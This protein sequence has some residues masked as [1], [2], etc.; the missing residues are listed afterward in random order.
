MFKYARNTKEAKFNRSG[1]T[2]FIIGLLMTSFLL[3]LFCPAP[4]SAEATFDQ[5]AV[6]VEASLLNV[7]TGPSTSYEQIKQ[8]SSGQ[9][10]EVYSYDQDW[11]LVALEGGHSGWVDA[12]Y[13]SYN[14]ELKDKLPDLLEVEAEVEINLLNMRTG[15]G[16]DYDQIGTLPQKKEATV[17]EEKEG[18]LKV[19]AGEE[20]G[21]IS[22]QYIRVIKDKPQEKEKTEP[23]TYFQLAKVVPEILRVR[24]GPGLDRE[25]TEQAF[26]GNHLLILDREKGWHNVL[27]PGGAEGWVSSDYTE[28]KEILSFREDHQSSNPDKNRDLQG[29]TIVLDPGHGGRDGGATGINGLKEKEVCLS[30][31]LLLEEKLKEKGARVVLTRDRDKDLSMDQ[32]LEIESEAG[33]DILVSIHANAHP[34]HFVSGTETFYHPGDTNSEKSYELASSLQ[35]EL[36]RSFQLPCLGVK[37]AEFTILKESTTPSA[38]VELAFLSNAVDAKILKTEKTHELAANALKDAILGYFQE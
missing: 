22:E 34:N 6:Q 23:E 10:L 33:A 7:R 36:T 27:L 19:K 9:S 3:L 20:G 2:S 26:Q 35:K 16:T 14:T 11:I 32:R 1:G 37:E 21:W 8:V 24:S 13:T 38:L 15:P 4:L 29:K 18:W 5:P 30:V 12:S 31:S 25:Q 17:K 28:Q